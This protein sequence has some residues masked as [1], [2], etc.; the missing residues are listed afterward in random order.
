VTRSPSQPPDAVSAAA[1]ERAEARAARDWTRADALRAEI[2]SAGWKVVDRGFDFSLEPATPPTVEQDGVVRY[3]AAADVPSVLEEPPSAPATVELVAEDWPGDL[4]RMLAGLRAHA[5]AGTQVVVV[6]NA[7]SAEQAAR[8]AAGS[9]D[10]A[11]IA[12]ASPEVA[13]TSERLGHAAARNVGLRRARGE[14]VIVADT[15]VE[16]IGDALTP[17]VEAL[18]DPA[19]AVA[20]GFGL[21]SADLRR[22]EESSGP[23]VDAIELYWLGFRREDYAALGPLDEKFSFYRNLDIWWSLV[24]RAGADDGRPPLGARR[25]ELP[26]VRH[27]HRGWT[28]LS[29]DE[30]DRLSRRNFY[31]VLNRFRDRRDLRSGLPPRAPMAPGGP[32]P[33][34]AS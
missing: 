3:G 7:P 27:A 5:P 13:W 34:A 6:A 9:T 30:R 25:V 28:S 11:P 22:F 8:L 16:P 33:D 2:E 18:Q 23:D 20:G 29:D 1:R 19:I 10:L 14:V 31:R 17:V 15:S 26:L 32:P 12:G 4:A 21:V 24:L